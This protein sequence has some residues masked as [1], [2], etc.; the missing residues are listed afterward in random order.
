[1]AELGQAGG[2]EEEG[3]DDE[4]APIVSTALIAFI[5]PNT[6]HNIMMPFFV[7]ALIDCCVP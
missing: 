5:V 1:M 3:E 4:P 7:V 6:Y 2:S